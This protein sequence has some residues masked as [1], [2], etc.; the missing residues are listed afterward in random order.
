[1]SRKSGKVDLHT[2]QIEHRVLFKGRKSKRKRRKIKLKPPP[3]KRTIP[4]IREVVEQPLEPI[5]LV[6]E[7]LNLVNKQVSIIITPSSEYGAEVKYF[8]NT[9]MTSQMYYEITPF[10]HHCSDKYSFPKESISQLNDHHIKYCKDSHCLIYN[11]YEIID[12]DGAGLFNS[13]TILPND[14]PAI[15]Y[16][17]SRNGHLKYSHLKGNGWITSLVDK[18][19]Y[20]YTHVSMTTLSDGQPAMIC[21]DIVKYRLVFYYCDGNQWYKEQLNEGGMYPFL[22]ILSNGYPAISYYDHLE[23]NLKVVFSKGVNGGDWVRLTLESPDDIGR[24]SKLEN[25][26]IDTVKLSYYN[27][28]NDKYEETLIL[29]TDFYPIN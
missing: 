20:G 10:I 16:F 7:P 14:K 12:L 11:E 4:I 23:H 25:D 17:D 21:A 26:T 9:P 5:I 22:Y 18:H 1:M 6:D 8:F 2:S 3:K 19:E 13:I 24:F 15:S 28:T 27:I 29:V